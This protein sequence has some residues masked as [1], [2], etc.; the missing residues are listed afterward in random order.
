MVL[1]HQ[2]HVPSADA[3]DD[4]V[5]GEYAVHHGGGRAHGHQGV[6]VGRPVPQGLEA[7]LVVLVVDIEDGK[8]QQQLGQGVGPH[9][10][11]PGQ[12]GGDRHAQHMP[13]GQVEQGQQEHHGPHEAAL[14]PRQLL[15]QDV[16]GAALLRLG[17]GPGGERGPIARGLHRLDD[18]VGGQDALV[19][20]RRHGVGH[21]AH[22]GGADALQLAHRLLHM[23]RAGGTAHAR[24]IEFLLHAQ[25]LRFSPWGQ[26]PRYTPPGW[27]V[28]IIPPEGVSVKGVGQFILA[29]SALNTPSSTQRFSRPPYR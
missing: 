24:N 3:V 6:H 15:L 16:V 20:I 27:G 18:V 1:L 5:Q 12:E 7:A 4:L 11:M 22:V 9:V 14:H 2:S 25:Y 13:H 8:G 28:I 26:R 10:L 23:G 29:R 19:K 17:P 21:Q